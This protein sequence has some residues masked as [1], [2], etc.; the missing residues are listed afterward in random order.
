MWT[1]EK[2]STIVVDKSANFGTVI[3]STSRDDN[4]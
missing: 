3:C 1:V 2:V 4:K